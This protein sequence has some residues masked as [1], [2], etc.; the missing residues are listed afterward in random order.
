MSILQTSA[1]VPPTTVSTALHYTCPDCG[2]PMNAVGNSHGH[3]VWICPAAVGVQEFDSA[4]M[5]HVMPAGDPHRKVVYYRAERIAA[6]LREGRTHA[7]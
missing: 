7:A 6:L 5:R 1:E 3:V 4:T 2:V